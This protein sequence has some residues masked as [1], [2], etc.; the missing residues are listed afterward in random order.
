MMVDPNGQIKRPKEKEL[1]IAQGEILDVL[2]F[3]NHKMALCQNHMGK[4]TL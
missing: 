2:Q 3:T 1:A 4:C